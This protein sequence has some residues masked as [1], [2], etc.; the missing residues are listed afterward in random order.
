MGLMLKNVK[1]IYYFWDTKC[2]WLAL[3]SYKKLN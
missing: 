1:I 3:Y 2:V